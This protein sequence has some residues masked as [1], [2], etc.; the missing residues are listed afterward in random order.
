[1]G[2]VF[3]VLLRRDR[4]D[5]A[6]DVVQAAFGADGD[7]DSHLVPGPVI[8]D[9]ELKGVA[10]APLD[11]LGP[12]GK[13]VLGDQFGEPALDGLPVFACGIGIVLATVVGGRLDLA[14]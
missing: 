10:Q 8:A 2:T 1:M 11:V 6:G 13:A 12:P 5:W 9:L 14:A 4:C 3:R 7:P